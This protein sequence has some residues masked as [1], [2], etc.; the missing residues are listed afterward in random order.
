MTRLEVQKRHMAQKV[1]TLPTDDSLISIGS[2]VINMNRHVG[3][4]KKANSSFADL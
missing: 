1:Q 3:H 4:T 2:G